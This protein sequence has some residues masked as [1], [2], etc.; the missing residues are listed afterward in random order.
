MAPTPI[1]VRNAMQKES[2]MKSPVVIVL[3]TLIL[4]GTLGNLALMIALNEAEQRFVK[5]VNEVQRTAR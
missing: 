2:S 1:S 3:T 5:E 4:M